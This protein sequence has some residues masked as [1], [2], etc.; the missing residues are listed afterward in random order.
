MIPLFVWLL[1]LAL[2]YIGVSYLFASKDR[3]I[4][5]QQKR[6]YTCYVTE[7]EAEMLDNLRTSDFTIYED[8]KADRLF[9]ESRQ[10]WQDTLG[11]PYRWQ[12]APSSEMVWL[13]RH[14]IAFDYDTVTKIIA[15]FVTKRLLLAKELFAYDTRAFRLLSRHLA[16][17]MTPR[18]MTV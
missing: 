14:P 8:K 2:V 4:A 9:L 18:I 13:A 17:A 16:Y 7:K 1:F 10:A 6:L 3:L 12:T 15:R 11:I 5:Y